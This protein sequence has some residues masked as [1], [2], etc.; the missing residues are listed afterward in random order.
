[1]DDDGI[2]RHQ[3]DSQSSHSD[4]PSSLLRLVQ[5]LHEYAIATLSPDGTVLSWNVGAEIMTGYAAGEMIGRSYNCLYTQEEVQ[6]GMPQALLRQAACVGRVREE[7]WRLRKDGSQFWLT[8]VTTT[9][10]DGTERVEGFFTIMQDSTARHTMEKALLQAVTHL[11]GVNR[12][13]KDLDDARTFSIAAASHELQSPLTSLKGYIENLLE[14]VAGSLPEK[15]MHYLRRMESNAD[16]VL[17]LATM[18]LDQ[19]SLEAGHMPPDIRAVSIAEVLADLLPEFQRV[20]TKKGITLQIARV[21]DAPVKADR[22]KLEQILQNL[23][24]NALKFTPERGLVVVRAHVSDETQIVISVEDT[25][26]GIPPD[27]QEKVFLRFYRA[28]SPVREGVGLG[29]AITKHL[30]ELQGGTI[31]LESEVGRGTR[32]LVSL[33]LA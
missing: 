26:C 11:E 25:G 14:G 29:L 3:S 6:A 27:D 5:G 10:Y 12:R 18:L 4:H 9:A 22:Q 28:P 2:K 1:M 7:G 30:V 20:A 8:A 17:R 13:L 15:V 32:F 19:A 21:T 24:H 23:L 16:R 33:P 31:R